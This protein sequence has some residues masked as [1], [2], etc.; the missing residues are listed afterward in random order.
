[1]KDVRNIF[2]HLKSYFGQHFFFFSY[3]KII[4]NMNCMLYCNN[5]LLEEDICNGKEK[6]L[7]L[8]QHYLNNFLS[9]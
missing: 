9:S 5:S 4:K 7:L 1:M 6:M 3:K 2:G 8:L